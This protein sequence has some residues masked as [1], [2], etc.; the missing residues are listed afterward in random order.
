M[1]EEERDVVQRGEL[2]FHYFNPIL[3]IL[4]NPNQI[5]LLTS[6]HTPK[7]PESNPLIE[8]NYIPKIPLLIVS[9]NEKNKNKPITKVI[10]PC[11]SVLAVDFG[12]WF[13]GLH[14]IYLASILSRFAI[15]WLACFSW[16]LLR[17]LELVR[18]MQALVQFPSFRHYLPCISL[19]KQKGARLKK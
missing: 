17:G 6:N 12:F 11:S 16:N 2:P 13:H 3:A 8:S 4:T 1:G 18:S 5:S 15:F 9:V 19:L 10:K 7:I 14:Y